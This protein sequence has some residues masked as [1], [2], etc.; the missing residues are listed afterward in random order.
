VAAQKEVMEIAK[1]LI[2]PSCHAIKQVPL[3]AEAK[4]TM[5]MNQF[6][7]GNDMSIKGESRMGDTWDKLMMFFPHGMRSD[8]S[9]MP[10]FKAAPNATIVDLSVNTRNGMAKLCAACMFRSAAA[11]VLSAEEIQTIKPVLRTFGAIQCSWDNNR[12][13]SSALTNAIGLKIGRSLTS[14]PDPEQLLCI[15]E[16]QVEIRRDADVTEGKKFAASQYLDLC[17]NNYNSTQTAKEAMLD[18]FERNALKWAAL[19]STECRSLI[20]ECWN[21]NKCT[22]SPLYYRD[23]SKPE[24]E[25]DAVLPALRSCSPMWKSDLTTNQLTFKIWVERQQNIFAGRLS[26]YVSQSKKGAIN[27]KSMASKLRE[28]RPEQAV[29][30]CTW[31]AN[32]M[33]AIKAKLGHYYGDMYGRFLRGTLDSAIQGHIRWEFGDQS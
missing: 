1:G 10:F 5:S 30:L 17:V 21:G 13:L 25:L 26:Q 20:K 7:F 8:E 2:E 12:D 28:E 27:L 16:R 11:D 19:Q 4:F 22:E 31:W 14:R 18:N 33:P 6:C 15:F 32:K 9:I 29:E 24:F 23:F 3:G